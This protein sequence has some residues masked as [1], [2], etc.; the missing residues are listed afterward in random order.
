MTRTG[1]ESDD[2]HNFERR[3]EN[4]L[5]LLNASRKI[6]PANREKILEFMTHCKAKELRKARQL[7]YLQRLTTIASIQK[8][9]GFAEATNPWTTW[10]YKVA[11]KVFWRW[12]RGCDED[13][14]ETA[15]IKT[16]MAKIAKILPED[17]LTKNEVLAILRAANHP[18][19]RAL[20][21]TGQGVDQ[22]SG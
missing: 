20:V 16:T 7:F 3:Y 17:L 10:G 14:P 1:I 11:A 2:I 12:L 4:A 18:M 13:P 6:I 22:T 5:S 21:I 19:H 9:K 8:Q 15:W